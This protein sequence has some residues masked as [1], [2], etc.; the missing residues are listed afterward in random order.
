MKDEE[1]MKE[2]IIREGVEEEMRKRKDDEMERKMIKKK[3][4]ERRKKEIKEALYK[5]YQKSYNYYMKGNMDE[6]KREQKKIGKIAVEG[7][8]LGI[9]SEEKK[10]GKKYKGREKF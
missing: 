4:D 5:E 10:K 9:S 8:N 1:E 2:E 6:Y 7:L 3:G